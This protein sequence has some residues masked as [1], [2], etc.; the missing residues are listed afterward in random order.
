MGTFSNGLNVTPGTNSTT[1]GLRVTTGSYPAAT[2]LQVGTDTLIVTGSNV[3][4]GTTTPIAPLTVVAGGNFQVLISGS[5]PAAY[6]QLYFD[7][8]GRDFGI[9]VGNASETANN[10]ANK[11]FL[12]DGTAP[13][14]RLVVDTNG[15]LGVGT[16]TPV[17]RLQVAGNVSASSYT[18]SIQNAVG[19]LGTASYAI[20]ADLLDGLN[21]TVFATTGSNTFSGIQSISD[22]TNS[23]LWSNGA[24]T[25]AGGVGI[26][27]DVNI[28]GSL[29]ILGLL[30]AV[31]QSVQYVTSSQLI[32][33]DNK[34]I[35]NVTDLQ[36]FG[37]LSVIDSG[38]TSPTTASI[39]WDSL[40]HNFIYENLSGSAYNSALFIAG[41]VN[42]GA[43][44]NEQGLTV[45]RVPVASGT[46]HIDSRPASSSIR[47]DFP[48][49]LTHVEA[50]LVVTGSMTA[51]GGLT[52]SLLGTSSWAQS[53][54]VAISASFASIG[55][56]TANS[57]AL[58]NSSTTVSSSNIFQ[59]S[60]NI[61]I[62]I[63]SPE[64][65]LHI[66]RDGGAATIRLLRIDNSNVTNA[67]NLYL[68]MN[69]NKDVLW[70]QGS[71]NGG[72]FWNTGNRGYGFSI[73]ATR[74]VTIDQVGRVGI[75]TQT[76]T[77]TLH[78]T[79]ST[80]GLLKLD[81]LNSANTLY[82]SSS[83]DVGINTG[84]P[85]T[86]L[87]VR[88]GLGL[89]PSVDSIPT[90]DGGSFIGSTSGSG[91]YPFNEFGNLILASRTNGTGRDI[92]FYTGTTLANRMVIDRT[93]NVGIGTTTPSIRLQVSGSAVID[94]TLNIYD[95]GS[96]NFPLSIGYNNRAASQYIRVNSTASTERGIAFSTAGNLRWIAYAN[97]STESTGDAGSNFAISAYNDAGTVID[98]PFSI[99][100]AASGV[101]TLNR[102]VRILTGSSGAPVISPT[103]DTNTGIYFPAPDN[104]AFVEGGSEAMRIDSSANV[105]IGT[106]SPV[107][108]L[109]IQGNVSASS[110]TS[111]IN[112]AVGFFGTSSWAASASVASGFSGTANRVLYNNASN[113]TTTSA[114]LTF[115]GTNLTVGGQL[116]A[117]TKSFLIN[118][119]TKPGKKLVYGVAEGPEHSVFVRGRLTGTNTIVLPNEWE[120]LVD[121]ESITVQLTAIGKPQKLFVKSIDRLY[122]TV[123]NGGFFS[124]PID[125]YYFI[126]ATRKDV[127]P[128]QTVV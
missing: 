62:G 122:I 8:T 106:T 30:T 112:N 44:G 107:N 27:R 115:D 108:K 110:Y 16:T 41:P 100:R 47:V 70:S 105:G 67:Q 87:E 6:S 89:G 96:N 121:L 116:N 83:G 71:A 1:L 82:V 10:V 24:L 11:F 126:Q 90:M 109:Q 75:G 23:T 92:V 37:G 14:I 19:F 61:G 36:R 86:K 53:A 46:D 85:Q 125:C 57:I 97:S 25:V 15:N 66:S 84:T 76:P 22:T 50:G 111:S 88:G 79:A 60:N 120:W 81:G 124:G 3:G 99:V 33:T 72:T 39:Y 18:S 128:L 45:N 34:I 21:S 26:G 101:I 65:L 98:T 123:E 17:N 31:S 54:S 94:G 32:V 114:N 12:F 48:S 74:S 28:S 4:I 20:N 35:V 9:G 104:I 43:L 102:N 2:L 29:T 118:H 73:N 51:Q 80:G 49:R 103:T 58:F 64:N 55:P 52:G 119:R 5:A 93:G 7:G 56:G 117:A 63:S 38:S 78:V 69:T 59:S 68:E 40:N 77:T 42:T 113:V 91:V 95:S 13:A 127:D